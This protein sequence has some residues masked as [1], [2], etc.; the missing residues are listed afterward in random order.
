MRSAIAVGIS[1]LLLS[2]CGIEPQS[3][4][5]AGTRTDALV[6]PRF[7]GLIVAGSPADARAS[8]FTDCVTKSNG[9][10]GFTCTRPD[11]ALL[12]VM[13]TRTI[14]NLNYPSD[15]AYDAPRLPEQT[16]YT[17]IIYQF[18]EATGVDY[19]DC[20]YDS[21]NPY[22]CITDQS[23]PLPSLIQAM[24]EQGWLGRGT[25]WGAD[26]VKHSEPFKVSISKRA[27]H[28]DGDGKGPLVVEVNVYP[29]SVEEVAE[30]VEMIRTDQRNTASK[31][32]A[33]ASFV[34]NMKA[35]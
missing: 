30:L 6:R 15:L 18:P 11:A 27:V 10:Y 33:N 2:A 5:E 1:A 25:R 35:E 16:T 34:E 32:D 31:A 3:Q 28:T 20:A 22:R 24:R 4:A 8:G 21:A 12:G 23:L 29:V 9:Y 17:S 19:K 7:E 14:V 26:Y 13:P